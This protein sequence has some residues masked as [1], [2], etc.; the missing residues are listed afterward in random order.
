MKNEIRDQRG[1]L[2]AGINEKTEEEWLTQLRTIEN[3]D[4]KETHEYFNTDERDGDV[5]Q[6]D[7]ADDFF[8]QSLEVFRAICRMQKKNIEELKISALVQMHESYDVL[9]TIVG[10]RLQPLLHT[11]LTVHPRCMYPIVTEDT[12]YFGNISVMD[13]FD[14]LIPRHGESP[15]EVRE[16][17]IVDAIGS[18]DTFRKIRQIIQEVGEDKNIA[19]D[20]TGGKKSM[21]ASAF[22]AAAIQKNV[23]IFYVD[24]ED[25]EE[26][27]ACCGTEFL[28]KLENPYDI[29]NVELTNKAEELFDH[30]NYQ[31][32]CGILGE[33]EEKLKKASGFNLD[34][35]LENVR[36][37]RQL[38][39]FYENW[40]QLEYEKAWNNRPPSEKN[41]GAVLDIL[42][43]VDEVRETKSQGNS[44][45]REINCQTLESLKEESEGKWFV[46]FAFDLFYN[47]QRR[48]D[49]GRF[50]DAT[51]RLTR[52]LEVYA[53]YMLIKANKAEHVFRNQQ[54]RAFSMKAQEMY[55]ELFAQKDTRKY[56]KLKNLADIR[57]NL[58]I[59]HWIGKGSPDEIRDLE[60]QAKEFLQELW[61]EL[62]DDLKRQ[63]N[64]TNDIDEFNDRKNV[65]IFRTADE[66]TGK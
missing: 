56:D 10:F 3:A 23:H 31:A 28:N 49:Q 61:E 8:A 2:L 19:I 37:L 7:H 57:N 59:I 5:T 36:S 22:L 14:H 38:A 1:E 11:I 53:Q 24:F 44:N 42:K 32:A 58:S 47:A 27:K 41:A 65:F 48:K 62:D 26:D 50:E 33:I 29:Y 52:V 63:I 20:I 18:I 17:V 15:I 25:Y 30:H 55:K 39:A 4:S 51:I 21:D 66:M 16:P 43:R 34:D 54:G 13:Y 45:A 12:E 9:I 46:L 64:M 60:E 40:D 35:L 6:G